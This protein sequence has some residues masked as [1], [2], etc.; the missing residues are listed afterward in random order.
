[1][2]IN[3]EEFSKNKKKKGKIRDFQEYVKSWLQTP[4]LEG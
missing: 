4:P 1:M 2:K 3:Q